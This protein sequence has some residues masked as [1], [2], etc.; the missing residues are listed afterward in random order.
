MSAEAGA[1]APTDTKF[2]VLHLLWLSPLLLVGGWW[3][4]DLSFQW[5]SLVE[6]HF[7]WIVV[8]LAAYLVWERWPTRPRQDEPAAFGLS[9]VLAV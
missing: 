8:M 3:V 1:V 5:A 2:S 6:Y 7:G 4:H 9:L